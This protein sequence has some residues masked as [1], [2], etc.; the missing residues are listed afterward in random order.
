[1]VRLPNQ[2]AERGILKAM[3][4]D[5]QRGTPRSG[6]FGRINSQSIEFHPH[7]TQTSTI[8]MCSLTCV[9]L[10]YY[11]AIKTTNQA[12]YIHIHQRERRSVCLPHYMGESRE[13]Y[14]YAI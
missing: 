6:R 14:T 8:H 7:A 2:S 12:E 3:Q 9:G 11:F 4:A 13:L 5:N 10:I 1:M